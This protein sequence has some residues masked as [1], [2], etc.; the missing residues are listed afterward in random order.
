MSLLSGFYADAATEREVVRN[1][2][3]N[4]QP[5]SVDNQQLAAE[6][7]ELIDGRLRAKTVTAQLRTLS[8]MI[9]EEGIDRI[10]LLK[11]NVEKSELDVLLGLGA[12]DWPK[13][14]QMVIEVDK[15]ENLE[16]I[17]TML[18]QQ[19]FDVQVEQDPLLKK[20]EL[21]YVYAIRPTAAGSRLVRQQPAGAYVR[22]L[23][24]VD[25]EVLTPATLRMYLKKRLPQ[26]MIPSAFVLMDKFPLTSNGKIDRQA[27]PALAREEIQPTRDF[28]RPQTETEK[29]LAA[30]WGELLKVENIDVNDDFFD[31]GGHSLLA[32]KSV[33]RIRDVFEVDLQ[34]R[35]LFE[36]STLA[37]LAEV[38]DGLLWVTKPKA[39]TRGAADREEIEL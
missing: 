18:E 5:E 27:L 15:R 19:G 20:T 12:G 16:P 10:D 2:V 3:L 30:I 7:G 22:S 6:V 13:I 23:P 35:N 8:S 21:C 37:G 1:Y 9:A 33:S 28:V 29:A 17:T 14:R 32:I 38:I 31:L 25:E 39:P 36:R 34:L 24:P 4:Q 11:V 26:Y